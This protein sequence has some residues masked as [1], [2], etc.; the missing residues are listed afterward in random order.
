[1]NDALLVINSGSSSVKFAAYELAAEAALS[2]IGHGRIEGIGSAPRLLV[3]G[4]GGERLEDQ[5]IRLPAD[6]VRGPETAFRQLFDWLGKHAAGRRLLA[7]GHRVVH[8]GD[9]FQKPALVTPAILAQLEKLNSLAPLHQPHNLSA[10]RA[11]AALL[12]DLPQVA[13]FDTEFHTTQ[14]WVAQACALPRHLTET[15][16]KRYGFHGLSYE[17]IASVL[18]DHL[19]PAAVSCLDMATDG[20]SNPVAN[21][22]FGPTA[23]GRVVVAHLGNGASLCAMKGRRSVAS[24]MGF[25][26][27]DGL[28]MGTR[29]GSLDPGIVLHLMG[30]LGMGVQT[31]EKLLYEQSGLL[32]V[33]GLSGDMRTVAA[34]DTPQ[35]RQAI[36]LYVYRIAQQLGSLAASLGGIDALVF[37]AGIGENSAL[38]RQRVGRDAAWLGLELD[39]A[40]NQAAAPGARRISTAGS[41]VAAWVIPTNEEWMIARH[42]QA[43]LQG[44][45]SHDWRGDGQ[46][47]HRNV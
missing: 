37:T 47:R 22:R 34:S 41:R 3:W 9:Q 8:G 32:G 31:V 12:P 25:S 16:V 5:P 39:E 28:M 18:P 1:M 44:R 46:I 4:R 17:Y 42:T 7:V 14:P 20:C 10:I 27:L 30:A 6:P 13:C 35:A 24:T 15:G 26:T 33:S 43:V 11:I 40:A 21:S 2:R 36:E 23:D 19:S 45:A 38:I 29:C